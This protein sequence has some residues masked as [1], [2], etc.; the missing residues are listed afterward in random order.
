MHNHQ[1]KKVYEN[2][3]IIPRILSVA[4]IGA[5]RTPKAVWTR[6]RRDEQKGKKEMNKERER[7]EEA[8]KQTHKQ[9]GK[10]KN[11]VTGG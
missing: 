7:E 9:R 2:G 4:R 1:M 8:N 3:G 5:G 6:R 11:D 10:Q